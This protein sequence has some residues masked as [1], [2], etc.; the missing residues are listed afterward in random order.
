MCNGRGKCR[1]VT[2]LVVGVGVKPGSQ[3]DDFFFELVFLEVSD[4]LHRRSGLELGIA[5]VL[6]SGLGLGL[7]G[8]GGTRARIAIG[9]S[10]YRYAHM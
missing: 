8:R 4:P 6:G 5:S 10:Y 7:R 1:L 9:D 3:G 2:I